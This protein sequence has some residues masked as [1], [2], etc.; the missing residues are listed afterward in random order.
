MCW[1]PEVTNNIKWWFNDVCMNLILQIFKNN[2][3]YI[4]QTSL[5]IKVKQKSAKLGTSAGVWWDGWK[6]PPI[7]SFP[8]YTEV[9]AHF[10]PWVPCQLE[11]LLH[12]LTGRV[13]VQPNQGY[14]YFIT[15][16]K[17]DS[18]YYF[19]MVFPDLFQISPYLY[20]SGHS[21]T[22]VKRNDESLTEEEEEAKLRGDSSRF[23]SDFLHLRLLTG[24]VLNSRSSRIPETALSMGTHS[25]QSLEIPHWEFISLATCNLQACQIRANCLFSNFYMHV[26]CFLPICSVRVC[27]QVAPEVLWGRL[28]VTLLQVVKVLC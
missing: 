20:K 22:A 7:L 3:Y 5:C 10:G 9:P 4:V 1:V 19:L 16:T 17:T 14:S 8:P 27:S 25:R 15:R 13:P 23:W 28:A 24:Q 6:S 18:I 21:R 11:S 2:K 26:T 12:L